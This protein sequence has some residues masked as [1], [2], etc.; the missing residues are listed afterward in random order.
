MAGFEC[1]THRRVDGRRLDLVAGTQHDRF[2]LADY[3][4]CRDTGLLTVRDGIRWHLI[5]PRAGYY[6]FS[7]VLPQLRA[8]QQAG[9]Q[10][11][12]D[13]FHYGWPDDLD[14][15]SPAFVTRFTALARA[16][17]RLVVEETGQAPVVV[18][19]NEVSFVAWG[20]GEEGFL[21]PFAVGRSREIKAQLV[22]AAIAAVESVWDVAPRARIVHTDPLINIIPDPTRPDEHEAARRAHLAQ[23]ESWDMLAGYRCPELGGQPRY[24]DILG[25]NHFPWNQWLHG[26]PEVKLGHPLHRPL[27]HLLAEVY[28]RYK[29]P[30]LLT[31]VG[32]EGDGRAPWLR[33]IAREARA[34]LRAGTQVA[35]ICLY[36]VVDYPG[37]DNDRHCPTG[38]WGYADAE[39]GRPV[40]LPLARA[41]RRQQRLFEKMQPLHVDAPP[42]GADAAI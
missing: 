21:N 29:R 20:A 9:V 12:W 40:Y 36:P 5:E 2:A 10:V 41:L 15:F 37:W 26:G 22:R 16:F 7:S 13:L 3:A 17:A 33:Y 35:G 27:R 39:G 42:S 34:A 30:L 19:V 32:T 8:A 31:E 1:S 25:L 24:L 18:P 23:Y 38:L 4:R 6:D 11:I 28:A 14:F